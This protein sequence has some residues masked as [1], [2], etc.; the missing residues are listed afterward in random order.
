MKLRLLLALS[1]FLLCDAKLAGLKQIIPS[2]E[3]PPNPTQNTQALRLLQFD[4]KNAKTRRITDQYKVRQRREVF[5]SKSYESS[6]TWA[7]SERLD[8]N[9]DAVLRWVNSDSSITFRLEARTRGYVGLGFNSGRNMRGADLVVAWVD[10]RNGNAQ[11]LDCHGLEFEDRA[12][13]DDVQN[14]ELISGYQNDTHTTIEFRRLLDTCDRQDFVIGEDTTQILWA[15]GPPGSD[16][17]LPKHVQSGT[18]PLRLL[19]PLSKPDDAS[20]MQWDVRLRDLKI[21]HVM[22]TLFWCKIFKAPELSKKHHMVGYEPI[23]DSRPIKNGRPMLEKNSLSPVHHMVLYECAED[24]DDY[25]WNEWSKGD[26]Y[27]G[28][29]KPSEWAICATPVAAW[30]MGSKG[31]FLPENVGIPI[32]K[33]G[34]ASFYML[35]V[36]YDNQALHEVLD[37][38][39]IRIHY[40][41]RL[42]AHDAALLGAGIGVSALHVIPP[43][44][45]QY[46]TVGICGSECTKTMIP[47]DG[48]T[49][50]SVLLHAHG[51]AKKISLKHIRGNDE[52]PRVSEENSYDVRYQQSRIVPGGR[53]FL[54]GDTLITECTYDSTGRDKP[55][56]GGYSAT[57]E[58]CL[59]F[60]LYYPRT[61]LAGCYSMTPAKEFFETFG[62]REFY[63]VDMTQVENT[64][65]SSS[66]VE[67]PNLPSDQ[68]KESEE[69]GMQGDDQGVGFMK[70]LVIKEPLEFGN[71]TFMAHLNEMPWSEVLL[72]EQIEKTLYRGMHMTFCKK[73][74]DSWGA[75][76]QIQTYP[77]FT[78][79]TNNDTSEKSC[80]YKSVRLP[81]VTKTNAATKLSFSLSAILFM[82][83]NCLIAR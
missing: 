3:L 6:L 17:Q 61:P 7:H 51:T 57:Q 71:K 43:K 80:N 39:G 76:V 2:N 41:P 23:I 35:E 28:P 81:S 13:A 53:K 36:H 18:R 22:A 65:L 77:N 32:G 14:Y 29:N 83:I 25:A 21:P 16:G 12:V 9:G 82:S 79:L 10:D 33:R 73:N 78:E 64:F 15:L 1:A 48:I 11:I 31:E 70:E 27:Y 56:L 66:Y 8:E 68:G 63:G 55:I 50:V 54:K 42:R 69:G 24:P 30:A 45:R 75:P 67:Y 34:G 47:D 62:V 5:D 52:L 40:T 19:Q 44:Q 20:L 38:S 58:M 72:T 4:T 74:D 59:S 49:I 60:V 26:G 37:S 46:R